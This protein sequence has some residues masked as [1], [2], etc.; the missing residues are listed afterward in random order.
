M[1]RLK[2]GGSLYLKRFIWNIDTFYA[3]PFALLRPNRL[4]R[5]FDAT[6]W[7]NRVIILQEKPFTKKEKKHGT[8]KESSNR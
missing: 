6:L 1:S 4:N 8:E 2:D 3:C 7:F 5:Q